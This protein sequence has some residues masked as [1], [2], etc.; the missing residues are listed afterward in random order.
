[1]CVCV[2]LQRHNKLVSLEKSLI[3]ARTHSGREQRVVYVPLLARAGRRRRG[4]RKI[5][6]HIAYEHLCVCTYNI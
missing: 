1:M 4:E 2:Y 3:H 6:V 5:A